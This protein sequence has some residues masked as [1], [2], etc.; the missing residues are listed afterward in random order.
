MPS[1]DIARLRKQVSRLADFFYVPDEFTRQLKVV[2]DSYVDYTARKRA[3]MAPGMNLPSYRTPAV[4][5][6]QIEHELSSTAARTDNADAALELADRLWDEESLETRLLAAFLLGRIEPEEGRL[7]TR[8]TAWISQAGDA[9]LRSKLLDTALL[10]ARKEAPTIFLHVITEWL[11]PER[12]RFWPDAVRAA[13][14]AVS[15]P[16]FV[17]LPPLLQVLEPVVIAAPSQIQVDLEELILALHHNS[18]IETTYF[19]REVLVKSDNPMTAITFRR[20]A[21]SFPPELANEI[22]E[23]TR[24]KSFTLP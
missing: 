10:R 5:M 12:T 8:L 17:N 19:V 21:S 1:I 6:R 9:R 23:F 3:A 13:I 16:N 2:L 15:D 11:R 18:P 7:L 24:G 14:S 22:R 4:V 20:M